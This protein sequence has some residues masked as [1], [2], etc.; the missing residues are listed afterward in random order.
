[1][2][3]S[4]L[5]DDFIQGGLPESPTD[6]PLPS[7]RLGLNEQLECLEKEILHNTITR[8]RSTREMARVLGTSQPTVVRKLKKHGLPLPSKQN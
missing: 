7:Q 5:L 4:D 3:E 2:S 6:D 1:M 8:C